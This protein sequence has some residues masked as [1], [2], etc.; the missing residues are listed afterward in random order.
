[1]K[2]WTMRVLGVL[3]VL[4]GLDGIWYFVSRLTWH[5]QKASVVYSTREWIIFSLLSFCTLLMVS[6]LA[7]LGIRLIIGNGTNLRLAVAIFVAEILYFLADSVNF[8]LINPSPMTH[9]EIRFW[10]LAASPIAPQIVTGYPLLGIVVCIILL[11]KGK[12]VAQ[13]SLP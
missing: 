4:F 7:Y 6:A 13:G 5:F 10:G 11:R 3:N 12:V 1:M 2:K 8:V 9:T